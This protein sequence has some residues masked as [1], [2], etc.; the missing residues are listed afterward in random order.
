MFIFSRSGVGVAFT[1]VSGID[2]LVHQALGC[3]F[4]NDSAEKTKY[5]DISQPPNEGDE[6]N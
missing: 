3:F 5:T 2:P 4:V 6:Q 1:L